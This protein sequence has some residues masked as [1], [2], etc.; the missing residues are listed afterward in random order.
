MIHYVLSFWLQFNNKVKVIIVVTHC[1]GQNGS[2][3]CHNCDQQ[4]GHDE[5]PTL[6]GDLLA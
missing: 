3:T 2:W 6:L 4:C 1:A 5:G